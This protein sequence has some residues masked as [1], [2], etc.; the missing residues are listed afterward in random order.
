MLR[1]FLTQAALRSPEVEAISARGAQRLACHA[2]W[3]LP[4]PA[5]LTGGAT[6]AELGAAASFYMADRRP[7]KRSDRG[8][9]Q[10]QPVVGRGRCA[11]GNVAG[12]ALAATLER[13]AV[14]P[15]VGGPQSM[16]CID[17][18]NRQASRPFSLRT[19]LLRSRR[20]YPAPKDRQLRPLLSRQP[21]LHVEH[22]R[23]VLS[24]RVRS[25]RMTRTG[26]VA[27]VARGNRQKAAKM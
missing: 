16:F 9:P 10:T 15:A 27:P 11:R 23:S 5:A 18:A 2:A 14:R 26:C 24:R 3:R 25:D 1:D 19:R 17:A 4:S 21:R 6:S 20:R 13:F 12:P 7:V 8:R 22:G